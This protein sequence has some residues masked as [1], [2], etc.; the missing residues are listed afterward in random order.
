MVEVQ[1]H[2][3]CKDQDM[4]T[5]G[6]EINS[7]RSF[8][9]EAALGCPRKL[10]SMVSKWVISPTYKW[11]IWVFPKIVVPPNH[12]FVHRVF[13]YFHHPFWGVFKSPYFWVDT[14]IA[15]T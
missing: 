15:V 8:N 9:F 3:I 5:N 4:L 1:Y 6:Q 10:G 11:D 14:H 12:P 7:N 13:H 2:R